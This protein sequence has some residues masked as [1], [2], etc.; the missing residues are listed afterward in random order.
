MGSNS[1][2]ISV[3]HHPDYLKSTQTPGH[4]ESP[5]R[6]R[7]IITAIDRERLDVEFLSPEMLDPDKL[8]LVHGTRH[9]D[10][11]RNFGI[12]YMDPDTFHTNE[13]YSQALRAAGGVVEAALMSFDERRP[14]FALPRPPGHHA[15]ADF[16]IGF[17]YFNNV[18]IAARNL[19]R[20]REG[21]E[22]IAILD[23]DVHHG[24]G[25]ND[26]FYGDPSVL[27]ISTHQWGIFPGSGH[28]MEVGSGKGEGRTVNLPFSWGAGDHTYKEAFESIVMPI[29]RSFSP[30]FIFVSLGVDAHLMDP[31][32]GLA[33]STP[34]YL[35]LTGELIEYAGKHLDSRICVELEGGYH[36]Y[37]LSEVVVGTMA[38]ASTEPVETKIRYR[39]TREHG[40]DLNRLKDIRDVQASYWKL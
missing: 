9:I 39:D 30:D 7:E 10:R 11:V 34:G 8:A 27:F 38:L 37:A 26:I 22:K 4:P 40:P 16:N 35:Y 14:T 24:N 31:L 29:L 32:A 18:A 20:Y 12:G 3:F 21:A 6:V 19:Q 5:D 23:I 2:S 28:E 25:T 36:V 33:L 17:C 13:T 15:G 1:A